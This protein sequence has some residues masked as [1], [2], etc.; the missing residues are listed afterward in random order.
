[1][2]YS[3]C[4]AC[5]AVHCIFWQVVVSVG[6]RLGMRTVTVYRLNNAEIEE[7]MLNVL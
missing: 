4:A 5:S 1:M 3:I 2:G 7:H 6:H